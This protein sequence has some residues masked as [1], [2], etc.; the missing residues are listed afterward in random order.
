MLDQTIINFEKKL[1]RK[2]THSLS[3]N[4]FLCNKLGS[5]LKMCQNSKILAA[6]SVLHKTGVL[7]KRAK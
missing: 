4:D 1:Q 3:S 5:S 7:N 2:N 6:E